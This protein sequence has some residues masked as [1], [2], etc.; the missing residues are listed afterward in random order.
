ME[1]PYV[2][3]Y[4]QP[5]TGPSAPPLQGS[6]VARAIVDQRFCAPYPV[7]IV[8]VRKLMRLTGGNFVITDVNGDMLFT[9]KD[10]V[11]GLHDKRILLDGSASPVLNM[12]EKVVHN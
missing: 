8:I 11:F 3:A 7:D 6:G 4:P 5:G 2:Y 1:Q 12:R 9:V 10:P